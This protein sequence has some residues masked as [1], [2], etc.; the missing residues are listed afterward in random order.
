VLCNE[1]RGLALNVQIN[2]GKPG[3]SNNEPGSA[4]RNATV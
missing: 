2:N 3:G 1:I 4:P